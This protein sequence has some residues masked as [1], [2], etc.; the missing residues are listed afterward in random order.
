MSKKSISINPNF[1][2]VGKSSKK[3]EK[4]PRKERPLNNIK[5][6]NIKKKTY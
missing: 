6:N 1:L 5:P 4:K 3:K 2:K